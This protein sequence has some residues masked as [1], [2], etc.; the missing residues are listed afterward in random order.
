AALSYEVGDSGVRH[1]MEQNA[2]RLMENFAERIREAMR[3]GEIPVVG[4][5]QKVVEGVPEDSIVDYAKEA[6]PHLIVMGTRGAA[7]KEADMIGSVTAEV[8][9]EGRFT[10]LTVPGPIDAAT[11]LEPREIL[12]FC[13]LDQDDILA[14]DTLYRLYGKRD[15]RV[16]IMHIPKHRRFSD[17]AAE[18]ALGRLNEY[19]RGNFSRY[20]FAGVPVGM[21]EDSA[22]ASLSKE[23]KYDLIVIPNRRR[24]AFSRLFRP[25]LANNILFRTDV[26]MLVIPV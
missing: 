14:M 16:T 23:K 11:S 15:A 10:V 2:L 21:D 7:E 17:S 18:K 8:L 1:I 4:F 26:P 25:G 6:T 22:F 13:N 19:C 20:E 24:N 3:R 5:S 12:F 9:D